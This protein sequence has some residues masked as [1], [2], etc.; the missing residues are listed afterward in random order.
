MYAL[1]HTASLYPPSTQ[2]SLLPPSTPLPPL[3][4][5]C[6][7]K[8]ENPLP[9]VDPTN[10]SMFPSFL[11]RF[12]YFTFSL[13]LSL[14]V[15]SDPPFSALLLHW[16]P[17]NPPPFF[18]RPFHRCL[19]LSQQLYCRYYVQSFDL[20]RSRETTEPSAPIACTYIP[21]QITLIYHLM[22]VLSVAC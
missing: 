1:Q 5:S 15:A 19:L 22:Y 6:I 17:Y 14:V 16:L 20:S 7:A 10:H 21:P 13:V 4:T 3:L 9:V 12:A 11:P 18:L 8:P 2:D